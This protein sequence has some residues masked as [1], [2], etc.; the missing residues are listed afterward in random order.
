MHVGTPPKT[1]GNTLSSLIVWLCWSPTSFLSKRRRFLPLPP[2]PCVLL[3]SRKWCD[4]VAWALG[5]VMLCAHVGF[6]P[7]TEGFYWFKKGYWTVVVW[8]SMRSHDSNFKY[9][10]VLDFFFSQFWAN[11]HFTSEAWCSFL[12]QMPILIS[13]I[14]E[15]SRSDGMAQYF[16][17]SCFYKPCLCVSV[18]VWSCSHGADIVEGSDCKMF[19]GKIMPMGLLTPPLW[20]IDR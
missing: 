2:M 19:D 13:E 20:L 3:C 4:R 10:A 11:S 6:L 14:V 18:C 12:A 1:S 7:W 5:M 16:S 17:G 8:G 15:H 9:P